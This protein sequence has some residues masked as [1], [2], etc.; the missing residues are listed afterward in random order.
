MT[1][2]PTPTPPAPAPISRAQLDLVVADLRRDLA[3]EFGDQSRFVTD[4]DILLEA[5]Q[6]ERDESFRSL[7][8][9]INAV[10]VARL[11]QGYVAQFGGSVTVGNPGRD[12]AP[13]V[14]GSRKAY[15]QIMSM[16]PLRFPT[17]P[18][19]E[20]ARKS[21]LAMEARAQEIQ[22]EPAQPQADPKEGPVKL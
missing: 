1:T 5:L 14:I 13:R 8:G 3:T 16:L 22:N 9:M 20:E 19:P 17:L 10:D 4:L 18:T 11:L 12:G 6:Q 7:V 2:E 21:R 15:E